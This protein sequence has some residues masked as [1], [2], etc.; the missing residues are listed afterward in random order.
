MYSCCCERE[1]LS[2][3]FLLLLTVSIALVRRK[4]NTRFD[5]TISM[6]QWSKTMIGRTLLARYSKSCSP[7]FTTVIMRLNCLKHGDH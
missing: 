5:R 2:A 3:A 1:G 6:A 4:N 7:S